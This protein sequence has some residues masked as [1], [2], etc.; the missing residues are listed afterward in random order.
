MIYFGVEIFDGNPWG[1]M[2]F[3][4]DLNKKLEDQWVHL[5][6]DIA[7]IQYVFKSIEISIGIDYTPP[8]GPVINPKG[9]FELEVKYVKNITESLDYLKIYY[10]RDLFTRGGSKSLICNLLFIINL[11]YCSF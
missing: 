7:Y 3:K 10:S 4:L 9:Y 1:G 5:S 2:E 8:S 11:T 6:Y